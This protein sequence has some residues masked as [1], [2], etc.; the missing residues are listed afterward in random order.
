[1]SKRQ[2]RVS[3]A[4]CGIYLT[5]EELRLLGINPD[6]VDTISYDV[7]DSAVVVTDVGSKE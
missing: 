3:D 7:T 5:V 4:G 1:M 6:V 2:A